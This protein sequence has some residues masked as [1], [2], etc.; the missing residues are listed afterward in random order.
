M[1]QYYTLSACVPH[2]VCLYDVI[3]MAGSPNADRKIKGILKTSNSSPAL[4]QGK[5]Q[6]NISPEPINGVGFRPGKLTKT[7]SD[8]AAS[9]CVSF[10]KTHTK[11]T[12]SYHNAAFEGEIITEPSKRPSLAD[13]VSKFVFYAPLTR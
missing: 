2:Q 11:S 9:R 1:Y 3:L 13:V 4:V 6:V 5:N 10:K 12:F 7:A 8:S